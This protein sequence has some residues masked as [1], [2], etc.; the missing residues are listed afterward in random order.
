MTQAECGNVEKGR[1]F[2]GNDIRVFAT[3]NATDC[4][5]ACAQLSGCVA[6]TH[7]MQGGAN[8]TATCYLKSKAEKNT[9][10][11]HCTSGKVRENPPSPA[12]PAH[13]CLKTGFCLWDVT[14][15]PYEHTEISEKHPDVVETMKAKMADVL[16]GFH[17]Y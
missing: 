13:A 11:V 16:K 17:Q 10:S 8:K 9:S 6:W 7:N 15:D 5:D 3:S 2:P 14:A 1:C 12:P 4:C